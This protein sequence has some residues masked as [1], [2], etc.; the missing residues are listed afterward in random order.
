MIQQVQVLE[1]Y[2]VL[3]VLRH[4]NYVTKTAVLAFTRRLDGLLL[5]ELFAAGF[6]LPRQTRST[7]SYRYCQIVVLVQL[8]PLCYHSI[9]VEHNTLEQPLDIRGWSRYSR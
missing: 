6:A 2:E 1:Q 7:A 9:L 8:H 4:D 3:G 5:E